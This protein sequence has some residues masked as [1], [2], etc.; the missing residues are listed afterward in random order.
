MHKRLV[1]PTRSQIAVL[2]GYRATIG[3][4][5]FFGRVRSLTE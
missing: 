4:T 5:C 3:L 1:D 2:I